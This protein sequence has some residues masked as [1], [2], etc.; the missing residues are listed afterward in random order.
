MIDAAVPV[1]ADFPGDLDNALLEITLGR[2][3]LDV[4]EFQAGEVRL[5][6]GVSSSDWPLRDAEILMYAN[7]ATPMMAAA[8]A[9][10]RMV[11]RPRREYFYEDRPLIVIS[12]MSKVGEARVL[13]NSRSEP[14]ASMPM[15]ISCSVLAMAISETG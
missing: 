5:A 11:L 3:H 14:T 10:R 9:T 7:S 13:R 4:A 8:R 12:R 1:I 6:S 15:S 2:L